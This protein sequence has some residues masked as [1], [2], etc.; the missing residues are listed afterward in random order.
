MNIPIPEALALLAFALIG[1][2]AAL[3]MLWPGKGRR[4]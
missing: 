4:Q 1:L 2:G 3:A